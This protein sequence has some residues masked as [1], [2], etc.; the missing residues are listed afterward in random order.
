MSLY[1]DL[2]DIKQFY[3][4]ECYTDDDIKKYVDI[5]WITTDQYKEVT[6]KDYPTPSDAPS[7][8]TSEPAGAK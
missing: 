3:K 7:G 8:E 4:W 5:G 6:G 1:P 2:E